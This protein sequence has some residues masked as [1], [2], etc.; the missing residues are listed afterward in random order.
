MAISLNV[1]VPGQVKRLAGDLEPDLYRFERVR[2]THTLGVKRFGERTP[3]EYARLAP[4]VRQTIAGT[5]PFEA[6]ITG[7]E[8]FDAPTK[9]DS[10][11]VYLAVE[12]P[13]LG[14]LNARLSETFG[15]I[16]GIDAEDYVPHIT[17]AR[18]GT[19]TIRERLRERAIDPITWTVNELVLWD[20]THEEVA[21]RFSLPV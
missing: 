12:S 18:G 21:T 6:R 14:E 17:L 3:T 8:S 9:G 5:P 19:E 10:P 13:L 4:Q 7:I 15:A 1:P 16:E 2:R 11:V 20:A